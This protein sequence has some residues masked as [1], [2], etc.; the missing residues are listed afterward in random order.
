M[1]IELL[2]ILSLYHLSVKTQ[3]VQNLRKM[4]CYSLLFVDDWK[5]IKH[6]EV[7]LNGYFQ[8]FAKW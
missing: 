5:I 6:P 7:P 2:I 1:Q 3:R 4:I 8:V